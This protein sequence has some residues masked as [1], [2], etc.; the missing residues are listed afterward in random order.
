LG[1]KTR[2]DPNHGTKKSYTSWVAKKKKT[3]RRA[4]GRTS[5]KVAEKY[6]YRQSV[7]W[8][9]L[10]LENLKNNNQIPIKIY[11]G[12][13]QELR[14]QRLLFETCTKKEKGK[15]YITNYVGIT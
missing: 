2:G 15:L 9:Q 12:M 7:L 1:G 5:R 4:L 11:T 13:R 8:Q 14:I 6:I 10:L 3:F